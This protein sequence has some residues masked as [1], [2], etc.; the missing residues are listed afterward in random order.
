MD[1]EKNIKVSEKYVLYSCKPHT[2]YGARNVLAS[3]LGRLY[4]AISG[5]IW[6]DQT[7]G[8][9]HRIMDRGEGEIK[10]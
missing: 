10:Y 1:W 2:H 7:T 3:S 4:P 9:I 5:H 6:D 8:L